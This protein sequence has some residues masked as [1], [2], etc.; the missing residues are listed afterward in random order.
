MDCPN[1]GSKNHPQ[2]EVCIQCGTLAAGRVAENA[3]AERSTRVLLEQYYAGRRNTIV[4][5][6][7]L[8]GAGLILLVLR[9]KGLPPFLAFLWTCWMF[10]GGMIAFAEGC[11]RWLSSHCQIKALGRAISRSPGVSRTDTDSDQAEP[12]QVASKVPSAEGERPIER[13]IRTLLDKARSG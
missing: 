8:G 13:P 11:G 12:G 5:V 6:L 7:L 2:S 9:S 4:G 1:C 10:L 3:A